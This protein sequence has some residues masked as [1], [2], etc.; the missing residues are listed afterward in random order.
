MI[1]LILEWN[2]EGWLYLSILPVYFKLFQRLSTL[3]VLCSTAAAAQEIQQF[4]VWGEVGSNWGQHCCQSS[5]SQ[6]WNA[7]LLEIPESLNPATYTAGRKISL[8]QLSAESS[9][10]SWHLLLWPPSVFLQTLQRI[11]ASCHKWLENKMSSEHLESRSTVLAWG[12][13]GKEP[14]WQV[15]QKQRGRSNCC[16]R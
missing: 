7:I 13:H 2:S 5:A 15:P 4:S 14:G 1:R 8:S 12:D 3:P 10:V 6:F 16:Q 9:R 11:G